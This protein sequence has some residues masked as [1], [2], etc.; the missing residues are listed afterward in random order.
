MNKIWKIC[1]KQ[2]RNAFFDANLFEI[3]NFQTKEDAEKALLRIKETWGHD[4]EME[5]VENGTNHLS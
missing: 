2:N 5:I 1:G 3:D 4:A